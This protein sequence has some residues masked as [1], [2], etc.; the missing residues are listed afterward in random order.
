MTVHK[1]IAQLNFSAG[2]CE[3]TMR[4][5]KEPYVLAFLIFVVGAYLT[6]VAFF[7]YN[8]ANHPGKADS[9]L[10]FVVCSIFSLFLVY[11]SIK[12]LM[13]LLGGKEIINI[14]M[15]ELVITRKNHLFKKPKTY[16]LQNLRNFKS[17]PDFDYEDRAV[18]TG[19]WTWIGVKQ[20]G[21]FS[22]EYD[23]RTILFGEALPYEEGQEIIQL[24]LEKGLI[25]EEIVWKRNV[26]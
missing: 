23:G 17:E 10:M 16:P 14:G 26:N 25:K 2:K 1:G 21:V 12:K 9:E 20:G 15:N 8:I 5:Q 6:G 7:F 24:L 19:R 13:W 4:S 11:S 18:G 3:I 22:F